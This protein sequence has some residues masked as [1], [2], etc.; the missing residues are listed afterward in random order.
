[1]RDVV[2]NVP[3][4]IERAVNGGVDVNKFSRR[5]AHDAAGISSTGRCSM[6]N[7]ESLVID[8]RGARGK[9]LSASASDTGRVVVQLDEG[10]Q[11]HIDRHRLVPREEGGYRYEGT[12]SAP[13]AEAETVE[14]HRI[15][16]AREEATVHRETHETGRVRINKSVRE[17][18][19]TIDEPVLQETVAVERV[20]ID[21]AIEEVPSVREEKGV[22]IIPVVEERL[23][24][25]KQLVL[26]EEI[27][28]TRQQS[29]QRDARTVTLR[30]EE[31]S[32]EREEHGPDAPDKPDKQA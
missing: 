1:M 15:P 9:L 7:P 20:P 27:R 32:I 16:L 3:G 14:E 4:S 6:S 13:E 2:V 29:E 11:V 31:V 5:E 10:H 28:V 26:K 18:T 23:V 21:R 24:I 17:H 30:S 12:F 8:D 25:T 19:E 22:I